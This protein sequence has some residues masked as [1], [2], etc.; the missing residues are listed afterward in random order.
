M[1]VQGGTVNNYLEATG[2]NWVYLGD[3]GYIFTLP[4]TS[5]LSMSLSSF[6]YFPVLPLPS[7]LPCHP[8][9]TDGSFQP[10]Q[11]ALS[12][13]MVSAVAILCHVHLENSSSP[14]RIFICIIFREASPNF[15]QIRLGDHSGMIASNKHTLL[16][17]I[18]IC[19]FSCLAQ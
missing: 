12:S 13:M 15:L 4:I 10:H 8:H 1:R 2:V 9:N 5:S 3:T 11:T 14:F 6:T 18:P 16:C 17:T 19:L 7:L